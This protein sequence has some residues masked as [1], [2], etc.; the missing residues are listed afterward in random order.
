MRHDCFRTA[1]ALLLCALGAASAATE[2][3]SAARLPPGCTTFTWDVA[4]ELAVLQ[5]PSTTITAGRG[6]EDVVRI[7]L[8]THYTVRLLPQ[9]QVMFAAPPDR[10][11]REGDAQA[12]LLTFQVPHDGRYRAAISTRHWIDLV[13]GGEMVPSRDFQGHR[14]CPMAHKMVEFELRAG[15]GLVLQLSADSADTVGMAITEVAAP[16]Q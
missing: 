14:A 5:T 7:G 2:P 1:F 4:R 10:P 8:D 15:R 11:M 3:P 12:G 9:S 13:D 6:V 16:E